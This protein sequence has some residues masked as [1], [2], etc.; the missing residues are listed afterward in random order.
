MNLLQVNTFDMSCGTCADVG[1]LSKK[2][3]QERTASDKDPFLSE[4]HTPK[5]EVF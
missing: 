1:H 5:L 4:R 2:Q 3:L